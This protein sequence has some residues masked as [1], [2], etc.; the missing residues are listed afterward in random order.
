M[1]S[2]PRLSPAPE[3][4]YRLVPARYPQVP[5][6]EKVATAADLEVV[7]AVE[8]WTNDAT[9][10]ARVARL[11]T[12]NWAF[13]RANAD[14]LMASFFFVSIGGMRFNNAD[15]GG[16]Y[17]SAKIE[18][19]AVEVGH[20]LLREAINRSHIAMTIDYRS[21]SASIQGRY[22]DIRGEQAIRPDIYD[23]ASYS[24]SQ[25]F[26]EAIRQSG[27]DGILFSSIRHPGGE[28]V[29]AFRPNLVADITRGP[30]YQITATVSPRHIQVK[31]LLGP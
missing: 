17:A 27:P 19:A 25:I 13:G 2:V 24:H 7:M 11:P 18:T 5:A 9:V 6:F 14:V 3:P 23:A 10:K 21:Y 15:L 8:G 1:T 16:W 22:A 26:G 29:V 12:V 20:H 28:N 4:T 31:T 30:T